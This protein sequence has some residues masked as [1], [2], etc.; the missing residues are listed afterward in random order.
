MDTLSLSEFKDYLLSEIRYAKEEARTSIGTCDSAH[1]YSSYGRAGA[2]EECLD[3]LNTW[4]QKTSVL[5]VE[6]KAPKEICE[7]P[8]LCAEPC[9]SCKP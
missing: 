3:F 9:P 1:G 5:T 6:D 2:L 4:G 7:L 8:C